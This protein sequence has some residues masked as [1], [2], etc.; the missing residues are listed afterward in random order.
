MRWRRTGRRWP[1]QGIDREQVFI[2][3]QSIGTEQLAAHFAEFAAMQP[4]A[5]VALAVE[6]VGAG[7]HYGHR[8]AGA[9]HRVG[10]REQIWTPSR[11]RRYRRIST[12]GRMARPIT[13]PHHSEHTLFDISD[14]PIDWSD[15]VWVQ[16]YHRGAMQSLIDWLQNINEIEKGEFHRDL[17]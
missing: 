7:T 13:S 15:P 5:G 6:P 16:R 4:P 8:R 3:A 10:Q 12:N 1:Q 2:V 17:I 14:E 9:H 11:R